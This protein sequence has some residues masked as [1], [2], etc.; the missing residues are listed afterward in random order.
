MV[1]SL[2]S[3]II[4]IAL[5]VLNV[6]FA[7]KNRREAD[8]IKAMEN[9]LI[10]YALRLPDLDTEIMKHANRHNAP[11]TAFVVEINDPEIQ[12]TL[13]LMKLFSNYSPN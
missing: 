3:C 7:R 10:D 6:K 4:N 1:L 9:E 5:S 11:R 8:R 12:R 13:M 2:I